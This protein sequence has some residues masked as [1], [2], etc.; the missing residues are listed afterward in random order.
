MPAPRRLRAPCAAA[1]GQ[2]PG[3]GECWR[4]GQPDDLAPRPGTTRAD[5][6]GRDHRLG[7]SRCG[8]T[9]AAGLGGNRPS[10]FSFRGPAEPEV[11]GWARWPALWQ[12]AIDAWS[13]GPPAT[14]YG[15]L[16]RDFHLGNTLWQS[17]RVTGL[18]DWAETSWGPP[19]LDV[20]HACSDFAMLHA[21]ADGEAFRAAYLRQGG[22]LDPDPDAARFWVVSDILGFLPDPAH[23]LTAVA[24]T[25]PDLSAD[26][27]R[28]GLEDFLALTLG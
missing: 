14:P 1:A 2:R 4:P 12:Q 7:E 16:H 10:T 15:L 22:R 17:D 3:R 18:I 20:A 26:I 13:A 27:V 8:G 24:R 23:I 5:G 21:T 11:P 25:R 28:R 9:P 19:D 6:A